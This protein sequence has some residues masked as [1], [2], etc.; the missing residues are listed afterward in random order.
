[1]SSGKYHILIYDP[2]LDLT[3][4]PLSIAY[5]VDANATPIGN[6]SVVSIDSQKGWYQ[7]DPFTIDSD[8][9][10]WFK[11]TAADKDKNPLDF[12]TD[13]LFIVKDAQ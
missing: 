7:T 11:V 3:A 8:H 1:M 6:L 9:L 12:T 10:L 2:L 13:V 4:T 5:Y